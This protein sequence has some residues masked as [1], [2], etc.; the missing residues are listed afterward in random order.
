[1]GIQHFAIWRIKGSNLEYSNIP[2]PQHNAEDE[3]Y[4]DQNEES[5]TKYKSNSQ[6][7]KDENRLGVCLLGI[8]E[9]IYEYAKNHGCQNPDEK[10][11]VSFLGVCIFSNSII[12]T[13]DS[14]YLYVFS[15]ERNFT[16]ILLIT[17]SN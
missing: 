7:S 9:V 2:I 15:F 6:L 3:H 5:N 13:T 14:G 1:M 11:K 17:S 12:T 4:F 16:F 8:R 10:I